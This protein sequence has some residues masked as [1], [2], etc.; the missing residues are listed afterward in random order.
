LRFP[1]PS[2]SFSR[3]HHEKGK[4]N[5]TLWQGSFQILQDEKTEAIGEFPRRV[6]LG[7]VLGITPT[8]KILASAN[9][10]VEQHE[11]N[12]QKYFKLTQD[13]NLETKA[14]YIEPNLDSNGFLNLL[15]KNGI[16][17]LDFPQT[18]LWNYLSAFAKV[19]DSELVLSTHT[20]RISPNYTKILQTDFAKE[21]V[22]LEQF[23]SSIFPNKKIISFLE[24]SKNKFLSKYKF[25]LG[26]PE[27]FLQKALKKNIYGEIQSDKSKMFF[28]GG[29]TIWHL[30]RALYYDI[31]FTKR[32]LAV[33]CVDRS[34]RVDGRERYF[35]ISNGQSFRFLD[36]IF[37]KKY[38]Y[39]SLNS[40][41]KSSRIMMRS[42]EYFYNIYKDADLILS[43]NHPKKNIEL[44]CTEC[45]D[46][47]A[48]CPTHAN[49]QA[50]IHNRS[51][52]YFQSCIECG[53]CDF[54]CPSGI[55]FRSKIKLAKETLS[56]A[57]QERE[58]IH[59]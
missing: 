49:P 56:E 57:N 31:P 43:V 58:H 59:A 53:L 32:H 36:K 55:D 24:P 35:L 30:I 9:G 16:Y 15:E 20:N 19:S 39:I 37:F 11:D 42:E 28:L 41:D 7:D 21:I 12:N 51:K 10:I 1:L 3:R 54:Y 17:S 23:L 29:E 45:N 25:P 4:K 47:D 27:Y 50:L 40:F 46:C 44:P 34:G 18:A 52:F 5:E 26:K 38:K 33:E 14:L 22:A 2:R 13:G 48:I 6:Q 8:H